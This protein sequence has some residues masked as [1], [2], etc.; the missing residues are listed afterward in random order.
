M[1]ANLIAR[2]RAA[3]ALPLSM[4]Q[5]WVWALKTVARAAGKDPA[6]VPAHPEF[7]RKVSKRAAPAAIGLGRK[8]W[9][10][11]RSL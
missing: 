2:V 10:N 6:E 11:A 9:N 3:E 7:L 4:R 8:A 5:N 1:L